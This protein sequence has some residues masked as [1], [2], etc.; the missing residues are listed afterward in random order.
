MSIRPRN[1]KAILAHIG[2]EDLQKIFR[3][4]FGAPNRFFAKY[5]SEKPRSRASLIADLELEIAHE[6]FTGPGYNIRDVN[7]RPLVSIRD[8]VVVWFR[9]GRHTGQIGWNKTEFADNFRNQRDLNEPGLVEKSVHVIASYLLDTLGTKVISCVLQCV[10]GKQIIW[11][12]SLMHDG[13]GEQGILEF[14][15]PKPVVGPK[16]RLKPGRKSAEESNGTSGN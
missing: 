2:P 8:E 4:S 10:Q 1:K 9:K 16:I 11:E 5:R 6:E 14:T 3:V 13:F 15:T 7:G 12:H